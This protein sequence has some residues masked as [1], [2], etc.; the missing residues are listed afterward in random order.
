MVRDELLDICF[1]LA[2]R[3]NLFFGEIVAALRAELDD[4]GVAST[5]VTGEVPDHVPGQ[6]PV[7]VPPHEYFAL[8]PEARQPL[9]GRLLGGIFLC[10]EQPGTWFFDEN[11][12]L[13]HL[14]GAAVL[15]INRQGVRAFAEEG[16]TAEHLPLGWS[17]QWACAPDELDRDRDLDVVHLGVWSNRRARVLAGCAAPLARRRSHLVLSDPGGPAGVAG[18]SFTVGDEKWELL[19]RARV[20]LNVHVD[21]RP[22]CEWHRFAQAIVNGAV[23]VSEHADLV[24]PLEP[25]VHFLSAAPD[26]LGLA[27]DAALDDEESRRRMARTAYEHLRAT[28]PMRA[29]AERLAEVAERQARVTPRV[30]GRPARRSG[31]GPAPQPAQRFPSGV[32]SEDMSAVRSALK[33]IRLQQLRQQR[34]IDALRVG[35]GAGTVIEVARSRGYAAVTPR[36]TVVVPVL[37]EAA[38]VRRALESVDAQTLQHVEVVVVDDGSSDRSSEVVAAWAEEHAGLALI[39]LRHPVNQ[40]LGAAR[41]TGN[42]WARAR[43]VYMLDADNTLFPVS[44]ARLADRLESEPAAAFAYSMLAIERNGR[45][46]GLRSW[47]HWSPERL[48]VGN[49]IDAMALWRRDTVRELGGYTTDLRLHGWEDYDLLCRLAEAGGHGVFVREMLGR[50][51]ARA[52]SMLS[53]TDISTRTAV[54]VLIERYPTVMG[55]VEPPL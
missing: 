21:D 30:L 15:D 35:P 27:L 9:P 53:L 42:D 18:P 23:V 8:T 3:Q 24:A 48:R 36:V 41:N 7:L 52:H 55:G 49:A 45:P 20:L 32:G 39:A 6:V 51:E 34:E 54:G 47:S 37:D 14:H 10:A 40:G 29:S 50:Y 33:D 22:Y 2:P 31:T 1:V 38:T 16:L 19:R 43:L 17:E 11:A 25:G 13:A 4:L 44:L 5:Q 28:M 12:R 46:L 26:A